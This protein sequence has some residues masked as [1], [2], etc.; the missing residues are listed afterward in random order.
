MTRRRLTDFDG[1]WLGQYILGGED[2][3]TPIPCYSLH[4]WGEWL[5]HNDDKRSVAWTGNETKWVSTVFLGVDHRIWGKGPPI[6]FETMAFVH[7]GR[8]MDFYGRGPELVPETLDQ[9]RYSSWDDAETGH[10]AMVRKYLVNAKTRVG[11]ADE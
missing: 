8:T 6:L 1:P 9:A 11:T 2:G 5:Q 10:K 3:H 4:E 7:Q